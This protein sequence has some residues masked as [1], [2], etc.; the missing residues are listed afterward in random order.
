MLN[1]YVFNIVPFDS[2]LEG[3]PLRI[4]VR[5]GSTDLIHFISFYLSVYRTASVHRCS[6]RCSTETFSYLSMHVSSHN[7]FHGLCYV[8]I[9]LHR[10]FLFGLVWV[11]FEF[12]L[13]F[14]RYISFLEYSI[15]FTFKKFVLAKHGSFN[16][17]QF[18]PSPL[19]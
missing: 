19:K 13:C 4:C 3:R 1:W 8:Y 2:Q 7:I 17:L 5:R 18:F 14:T 16:F 6:C 10:F 15:S 12:L 11:Y 9:S